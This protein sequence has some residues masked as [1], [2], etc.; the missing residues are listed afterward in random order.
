MLVIFNERMYTCAYLWW[1][2]MH[3]FLS[4]YDCTN[5]Q[6]QTRQKVTGPKWRVVVIS[7]YEETI[8]L[9]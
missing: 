6:L 5:I 8:L 2:Q 1:A 7:A 9:G 4:V 3:P